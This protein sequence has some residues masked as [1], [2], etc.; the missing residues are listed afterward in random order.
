[1]S[2]FFYNESNLY[3][4]IKCKNYEKKIVKFVVIIKHFRNIF[5]IFHKKYFIKFN[6]NKNKI[7]VNSCLTQMNFF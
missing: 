4:L 7:I 6:V 3:Y 1:M 2:I 5:R